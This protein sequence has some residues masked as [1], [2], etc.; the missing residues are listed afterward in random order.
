MISNS[1]SNNFSEINVIID[2]ANIVRSTIQLKW[3]KRNVLTT[4]TYF[5]H[6]NTT[7]QIPY[8]CLDDSVCM[9]KIQTDLEQ[10]PLHELNLY[11][12]SGFVRIAVEKPTVKGLKS[13]VDKP[14]R[15]GLIIGIVMTV[16]SVI[17][18]AG[19]IGFFLVRECSKKKLDKQFQGDFNLPIARRH[20]KKT[21]H[22]Y[23]R[24]VL[25]YELDPY[26]ASHSSYV[27]TIKQWMGSLD[28]R[29]EIKTTEIVQN[30]DK[31]KHFRQQIEI[32]ESRMNQLIY[33][34]DFKGETNLEERHKVLQRLESLYKEVKS[35][36]K[37]NIIRVWHGTDA[38]LLPQLL[39]EGF[40][41]LGILDD[42]WF[43]KG[44]YFSS[45]AEY[46]SRYCWEKADP[47]LLM[48]YV[49]IL[50]PFPVT[51]NDAPFDVKP[52]QFSFYGRGNY[53]TH[54][55]H[56]IPV[57][58][59]STK[60]SNMDFRPPPNGTD[61]AIYDELVIFDSAFIL[62]QVVVHL[63]P[64]PPLSLEETY[65]TDVP[66]KKILKDLNQ[67]CCLDIQSQFDSVSRNNQPEMNMI[68][69]SAVKR[70]NGND[71]D[72]RD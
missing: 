62:P 35:N 52:R 27:D 8:S 22:N 68:R 72:Y 48:C 7:F 25:S 57:A 65:A 23:G 43:G 21:K 42:G 15:I 70:N 5:L 59:V 34:P 55:C 71:D 6:V 3:H 61:N 16:L 31:F 44:I 63:K 53:H 9:D 64:I 14:N 58:P 40:A 28:P 49:L 51:T 36:R 10:T 38:N 45:S 11:T 67:H 69:L 26:T 17:V 30:Q 29:V 19:V 13:S 2:G 56:Y 60:E 41:S 1:L 12:E 20:L 54:Q 39:G 47:C 18:L 32:V 66:P 4:P 24:N 50:N 37:A 33:Q 46:A